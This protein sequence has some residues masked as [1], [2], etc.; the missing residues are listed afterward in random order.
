MHPK[1]E[2][3]VFCEPLRG[4]ACATVNEAS[5]SAAIAAAER[6]REKL[7]FTRIRQPP[8]IARNMLRRPIQF[9]FGNGNMM[10]SMAA[11][12]AYGMD[13]VSQSR[14]RVRS[15]LFE[16]ETPTSVGGSLVS[17]YCEA[18][19]LSPVVTLFSVASR[20]K[21]DIKNKEGRAAST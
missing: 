12:V 2:I 7:R 8:P 20:G 9:S 16:A 11:F 21:S 3:L 10:P 14:P 13:V 6:G 4:A 5:A 18:P 17:D 1:F 15:E 19:A